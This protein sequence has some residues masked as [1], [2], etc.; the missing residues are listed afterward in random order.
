MGSVWEWALPW[1]I[2]VT[3]GV[4]PIFTFFIVRTTARIVRR[5]LGGHQA[6][7]GPV[8]P[9]DRERGPPEL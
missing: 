3:V 5:R 7:S 2:V 6:G 4:S 1:L 9:E 8:R